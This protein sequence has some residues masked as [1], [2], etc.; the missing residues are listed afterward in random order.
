MRKVK[1]R[2]VK[3]QSLETLESRRMFAAH[4]QGNPNT[5]ATIQAAVDA[6]VAGA[7]VTV[8]AGTYAEQVYVSKSITIRGAQSGVDARSNTR[9]GAGVPESIVTGAPNSS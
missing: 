7:I 2:R 3:G 5:Y 1:S 9:L 8:D 4:I 6:A